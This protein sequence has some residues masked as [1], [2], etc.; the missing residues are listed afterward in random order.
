MAIEIVHA[1]DRSEFIASDERGEIGKLQYVLGDGVID[2]RHTVV[3][4]A[5]EGHGV[6]SHLVTAALDHARATGL[7]VIPTCT[8]VPG[9]IARHPEYAD[10]V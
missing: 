5:A 7:R 10:L 3:Q 8:F 1:T 4:P 9:V 2:L 6:G